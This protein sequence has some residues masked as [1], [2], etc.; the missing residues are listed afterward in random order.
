VKGYIICVPNDEEKTIGNSVG[1]RKLVWRH[2]N[3]S[4]HDVEHRERR[5]EILLVA[6]L[7]YGVMPAA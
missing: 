2:E 4:E 6:A 7:R 1:V 5:R 3:V